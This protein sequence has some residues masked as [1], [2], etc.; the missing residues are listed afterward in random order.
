MLTVQMRVEIKMAKSQFGSA[1]DEVETM[2][3]EWDDLVDPSGKG[4]LLLVPYSSSTS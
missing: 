4:T 1:S 2:M 3:I